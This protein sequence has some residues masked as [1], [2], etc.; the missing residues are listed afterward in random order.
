MPI[1]NAPIKSAK[2]AGAFARFGMTARRWVSSFVT[3]AQQI[4]AA[5]AF[6]YGAGTTTVASLLGSGRRLARNRQIIY[7]KWSLMEGDPIVSTA[8]MLL[9]TSALGGHET[10]GSLVFVE[11]TP[12]AKKD[13]RKGAIAEEI[14]ADLAPLFNRVA[15]QVAYTGAVFGDAYARI[16]ADSRGVIDLYVDEMV[17]P[18]LVQPFE[19]GSRTVGYLVSVGE[20]NS[21][22]LNV[23][24]LARLKMPRTQWVPQFGVVEKSLRLA[25]TEDDIDRLPL[26]PGMA[27]GSLLYNAEEAYDNLTASLLGLVGQRWMD[28]IDEQMVAVNLESM[29]LEQQG[30]FMESVKGM[31]LASKNYAEMAVKSGRP[32]MERIRHIIPVFSEKQLTTVGPA[33]G[34]QPGRAGSISID[35]V[36]LHARLLSGALGVDLSMLG[37]ADQLSGGLGEGGFFRVS[38]QAAERA[39]IIRVALSEFFNQVID[40]HTAN[41]YGIVFDPKERPWEINFFGSISALEAEKQRTRTDSMNAG[42]LL[43]QAMQMMKEMGANKEIMTEFLAKTMLLDEGQAK[44]FATIV[45]AKPPED[46]GGFG[47]GGSGFGGGGGLDSARDAAVF[48]GVD[49]YGRLHDERGRF[50]GQGLNVA[51][52]MPRRALTF[53]EARKAAKAFQGRPLTNARSGMVA[54]VSRNTLDKML[55]LSAVSKSA[56]SA[57]QAQAVANLDHLFSHAEYGWAKPDRNSDPNIVAVH[58]LFAPMDTANGTQVVKLTVK[59]FGSKADGNRIYSVESMEIDSPASIWV[60]ANIEA[61]GLNSISTPYAGHV[62]SLVE[63]VRERNTR[64]GRSNG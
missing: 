19:R 64:K 8:L 6:L 56:S 30:R 27:G 44:L 24:Q 32:V 22:R 7:E 1:S 2:S 11:K 29:T 36:M 47:G 55:S 34:G 28:S 12:E 39:R 37:F 15:H 40:V 60:A 48:D 21:E 61:D 38:A 18:I 63:A 51:A 33:N 53:N 49:K 41:R 31:L 20:R 14:E 16:Y 4:T 9:V 46:G 26:M 57:D 3:P 13:K 45:D 58:R 17:R 23:S 62:Q 43:V 5:D 25:L 59:E 10:S 35:D 52:T 54:T 42:V 50:A